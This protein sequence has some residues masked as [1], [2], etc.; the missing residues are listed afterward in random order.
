MRIYKYEDRLKEI[1]ETFGRTWQKTATLRE[2]LM[3]EDKE[4][5]IDMLESLTNTQTE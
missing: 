2:A 4:D 5:R 1:Y 3:K